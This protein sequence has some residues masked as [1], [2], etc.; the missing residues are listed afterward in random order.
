MFHLA[1]EI[2]DVAFAAA[3]FHLD[4]H[5]YGCV[6]QRDIDF[7]SILAFDLGFAHAFVDAVDFDAFFLEE[8]VG[9]RLAQC[10]H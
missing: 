7:H 9:G 5:G 1:E 3:G 2:V 4:D 6:A 10:F 8:R